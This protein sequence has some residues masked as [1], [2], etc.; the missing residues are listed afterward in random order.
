MGLIQS[1][2]GQIKQ[3]VDNLV[4]SKWKDK[5]VV[6]RRPS[7]YND[8]NTPVQQQNRSKFKQMVGMFSALLLIIRIGFKAQ[9]TKITTSNVAVR[10]A[11]DKLSAFT[12]LTKTEYLL[13]NVAEGS[14]A[15]VTTSTTSFDPITGD[16]EIVWADNTNG[17]NAFADDQLCIG[18]YDINTGIGGSVSNVD[19]RNSTATIENFPQLIGANASDVVV[20][21]FFKKA[22]GTDVSTS[23]SF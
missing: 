20:Y 11:L 14:L 7:G 8:A 23:Q 1:P 10:K 3:K 6:K 17:V 4:F 5:N 22:T 18:A 12:S 15:P 19:T 16:V 2:L 9:A 13:V 21:F